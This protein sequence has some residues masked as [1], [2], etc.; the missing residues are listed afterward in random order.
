MGGLLYTGRMF[1]GVRLYPPLR[2][3]LNGG[4]RPLIRTD[5]VLSFPEI[6]RDVQGKPSGNYP[7][8]GVFKCALDSAILRTFF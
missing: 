1:I 6:G 2:L 8:I 5:A 3:P 4:Y 7:E